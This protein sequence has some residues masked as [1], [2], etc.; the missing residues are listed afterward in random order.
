MLSQPYTQF[1]Q[2]AANANPITTN[3]IDSNHTVAIAI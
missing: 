3:G 1:D 2:T